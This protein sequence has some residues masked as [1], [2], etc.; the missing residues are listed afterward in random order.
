M[1]TWGAGNFE[2][3]GA[4]DYVGDLMDQLEKAVANCFAHEHGADLDG[5]GE[6][7]LV[8]SVAIMELLSAHCGA[9]PPKPAVVAAWRERYLA[10][11]DKQIDGLDPDVQF[12]AERRETIT[13]TFAALEQRAGDFWKQAAS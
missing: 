1:G 8:P 2:S 10:I 5:G 13:R 7:E 12:K 11:Y 3:D 6:D 9:A 4:L